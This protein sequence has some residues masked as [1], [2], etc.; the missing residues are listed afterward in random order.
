ML[1]CFDKYAENRML[2]LSS[3]VPDLDTV[4]PWARWIVSQ[5]SA[6]AVRPPVIS[7]LLHASQVDSKSIGYRCRE[8]PSNILSYR[9]IPAG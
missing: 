4:G 7:D 1:S 9:G 3:S 5:Q 8:A 6:G 2:C